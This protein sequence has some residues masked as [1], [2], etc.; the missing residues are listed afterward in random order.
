MDYFSPGVKIPGS[1]GLLTLGLDILAGE[2]DMLAGGLDTLAGGLD[3]LAGGLDIL[4]GRFELPGNTLLDGKLICEAFWGV[5][6]SL[7]PGV[8]FT[9]TELGAATKFLITVGVLR[10]FALA[11]WTPFRILLTM[12]VIVMSMGDICATG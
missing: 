9:G 1:N 6:D 2:L 11:N 5:G 3:I 8:T 12:A 10:F 4:A 7:L